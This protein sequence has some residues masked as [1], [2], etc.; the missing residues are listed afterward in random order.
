MIPFYYPIKTLL[1]THPRLLLHPFEHPMWNAPVPP[2]PI[3]M[4][5]PN[6][7]LHQIVQD[8]PETMAL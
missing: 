2:P 5:W 7:P 4:D 1:L 8:L 6:M 3:L